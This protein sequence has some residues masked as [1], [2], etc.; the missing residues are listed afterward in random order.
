MKSAWFYNES[1]SACTTDNEKWVIIRYRKMEAC[2]SGAICIGLPHC[3]SSCFYLVSL[4]SLAP[5][6]TFLPCTQA[7]SNYC[8]LPPSRWPLLISVSLVLSD[9]HF[10]C[11]NAANCFPLAL[12]CQC[13][14]FRLLVTIT[15]P[16]CEKEAKAG[17]NI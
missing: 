6:K 8:R 10:L 12:L 7:G 13:V 1:S 9:F 17:E 3:F 16:R 14:W 5:I 2:S 15:I 4:I 11:A